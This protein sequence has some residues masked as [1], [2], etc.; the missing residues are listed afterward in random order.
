MSNSIIQ[1][2]A[3]PLTRVEATAPAPLPNTLSRAPDGVTAQALPAVR[4]V[5]TEADESNRLDPDKEKAEKPEKTPNLQQLEQ[6][7]DE[8][9]R[10]VTAM[11]IAL[12]FQIHEKYPDEWVMRVLDRLSQDLIRQIPPDEALF[13]AKKLRE[14][15]D[16]L[17]RVGQN[18]PDNG[19]K[20]PYT[21][22]PDRSAIEGLLLRSRT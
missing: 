3:I 8:L 7:R 15:I 12:E 9:N 13:L 22:T 4:K 5:E 19:P 18:T 14:F 10:L 6:L 1:P 11:A 20:N 16:T 21:P 17:P 2:P